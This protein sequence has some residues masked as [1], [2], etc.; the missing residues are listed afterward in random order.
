MPFT[1]VLTP[2]TGYVPPENHPFN[3]Y[4]KWVKDSA[5]KGVI[6]QDADEEARIVAGE[7]PATIAPVVAVVVPQPI[8]PL[9]GQPDER[10]TLLALAKAKGVKVD[11]RWSTQRI[12][13]TLELAIPVTE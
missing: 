6:V 7:K 5:G 10:D 9:V 3:E 13:K 4:P 11:A 8:A 12:K 1:A 2:P